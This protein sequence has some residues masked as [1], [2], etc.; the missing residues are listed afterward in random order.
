MVQKIYNLDL[1]YNGSPVPFVISAIKKMTEEYGGI[2]EDPHRHDL[3][4]GLIPSRT[5]HPFCLCTIIP[6]TNNK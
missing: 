1:I 3:F 2:T 6:V 5:L 4:H